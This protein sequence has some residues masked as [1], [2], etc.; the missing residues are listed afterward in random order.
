MY[1]VLVVAP[2]LAVVSCNSSADD[3]PDSPIAAP[4]ESTEEA[5]LSGAG[6]PPSADL[7]APDVEST[8]GPANTSYDGDYF[9]SKDGGNGDGRSWASAWSELDQI[10][11]EVIQPGDVIL[12]DGGSSEMVYTTRLEPEVS[13]TPESPV[14]IAMA[15][16]PGRNGK[17]VIFG[18]RDA[19]LPHCG[20]RNYTFPTEGVRTLGVKFS[21]VSWITL[22][23]TK[24]GGIAVHGHN[25]FGMTLSPSV[26]GITVRNVEIYNNGEAGQNS[27][28]EWRS[29]RAGIRLGGVDNVL[30]RVNIH[31]NGDD[32]IQGFSG[33]NNISSLTISRSWLHNSRK[34]PDKDESF[35]YCRHSD[36]LQIYSGG[37]VSGIVIEWSI[38]GPGLTQGVIL[39]QADNG[40]GSSV[41]VNDVT[42][43]DSLFAKNGGIS[44]FGYENVKSE[45]W[46]IHRV[47]S[48][49][50]SPFTGV[51]MWVEGSGHT[52][53]DS[54]F[55]GSQIIM[56]DGVA[57]ATGNCEWKTTEGDV[58][59]G[60]RV[61]PGFVGARDGD[62]FS[63]DDYTLRADSPCLG[64]GSSITSVEQLIGL[65]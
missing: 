29:S 43:R 33:D 1:A 14:V 65:G 24:W 18:G 6:Q 4:I 48:H 41:V 37:T 57:S 52:V 9:V 19:E 56:P 13:G 20:L 35:N 22:D 3:G 39:G 53:T 34:H 15:G 28:G 27:E 40:E 2:A 12:I 44:I 23:G 51:C 17:V 30:D 8:L 11:W 10:D 7:S 26:E 64:K 32:A 46:T 59:I 63:L 45:N 36:G 42:I 58:T 38:V 55:Y 49:C 50:P 31:D 60:R 21:R 16:E 61:D 62:A 25:G 5:S 54:V 47:T